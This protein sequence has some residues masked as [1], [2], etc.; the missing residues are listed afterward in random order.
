MCPAIDLHFLIIDWFLT[1]FVDPVADNTPLYIFGGFATENVVLSN[2]PFFSP[3]VS[4][5]MSN[6]YFKVTQVIVLFSCVNEH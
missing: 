2:C 5:S 6:T 1:V 4:N 3:C